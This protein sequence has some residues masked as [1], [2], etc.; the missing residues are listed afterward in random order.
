MVDGAVDRGLRP[1]V[2]LH[3]STVLRGFAERG[4]W[5]ADRA[6]GSPAV[7]PNSPGLPE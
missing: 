1:M 3:R 7:D 2:T 4:G 5:T 6:V